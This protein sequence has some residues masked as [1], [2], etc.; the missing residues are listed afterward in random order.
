MNGRNDSH[1]GTKGT[2]GEA[3][4]APRWHLSTTATNPRGHRVMM[5]VSGWVA[6]HPVAVC[7]RFK[8]HLETLR[9]TEIGCIQY[10]PFNHSIG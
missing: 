2:K 1:E 8:D 9:F 6:P 7:L 10:R 5:H 3:V 4:K